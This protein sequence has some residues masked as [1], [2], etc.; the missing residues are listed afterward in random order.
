MPRLPPAMPVSV[1]TGVGRL[2]V[3]GGS[4]V[5]STRL[6]GAAWPGATEPVASPGALREAKGMSNRVESALQPATPTASAVS[7]TARERERNNSTT[8]DMGAHSYATIQN[9][10]S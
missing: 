8:E 10:L 3:G 2:A 7:T 9:R 4:W 5:E 6:T 1:A